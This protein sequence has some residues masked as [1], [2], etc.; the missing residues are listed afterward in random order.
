MTVNPISLPRLN[1]T[2]KNEW[3]DVESN[4]VALREAIENVQTQLTAIGSPQTGI[5]TVALTKAMGSSYEDVTL[6]GG[7]LIVTPAVSSILEVELAAHIS[8]STAQE[9]L[10]TIKV[11]SASEQAAVAY[12]KLTAAGEATVAQFYRVALTSG[13]HTVKLRVKKSGSAGTVELLAEHSILRWRLLA[14]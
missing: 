8:L 9:G 4:D 10:A 11:D 1:Q 5:K 14:A 6:S 13:E 3:A 12:L 7:D 2:G